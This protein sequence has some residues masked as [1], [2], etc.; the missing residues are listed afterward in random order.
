MNGNAYEF[1]TTL[2]VSRAFRHFR[3]PEL[4][5]ELTELIREKSL[6]FRA[7][8]TDAVFG[9]YYLQSS[10]RNSILSKETAIHNFPYSAKQNKQTLNGVYLMKRNISE[11]HT[12]PYKYYVQLLF[13]DHL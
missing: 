12:R 9:N 2:Q 6:H 11:F 1:N 10:T 7:V 5:K 3:M 4:K 13:S 8:V